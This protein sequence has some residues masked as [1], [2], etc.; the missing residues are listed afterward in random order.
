M[1]MHIGLNSAE[2]RTAIIA[3]VHFFKTIITSGTEKL[4]PD[5]TRKICDDCGNLYMEIFI[6]TA[7]KQHVEWEL[8]LR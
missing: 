6:K 8:Q 7:K 1:H 3:I 5:S 2:I 4:K